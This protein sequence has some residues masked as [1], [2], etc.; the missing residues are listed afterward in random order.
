MM[1]N[2]RNE[3]EEM[4]KVTRV[5]KWRGRRVLG[6]VVEK[7]RVGEEWAMTLINWF[8]RERSGGEGKGG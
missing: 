4:V 8:C 7:A 2:I 6:M 5:G 3:W 1:E